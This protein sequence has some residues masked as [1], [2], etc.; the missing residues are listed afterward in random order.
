L[1]WLGETF[2]PMVVAAKEHITMALL[3][4]YYYPHLRF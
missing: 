3:N 1:L 4:L 2:P